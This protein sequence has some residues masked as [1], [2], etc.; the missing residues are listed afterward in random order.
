MAYSHM[1]YWF[2]RCVVRRTSAFF[3]LTPI[4]RA[5]YQHRKADGKKFPQKIIAYG[6]ILL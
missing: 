6:I 1:Y 2:Q 3:L 5:A 4:A